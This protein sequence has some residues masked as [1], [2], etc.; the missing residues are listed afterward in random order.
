MPVRGWRRVVRWAGAAVGPEEPALV[1]ELLDQA[2]RLIV[3]SSL[4]A[5]PTVALMAGIL[6]GAAPRTGLV[7]WVVAVHAV[8]A[9]QLLLYGW[10]RRARRYGTVPHGLRAYVFVMAAAGAAWGSLA[11]LALPAEG[12]WQAMVGLFVIAFMASN[13]VFAAPL[14]PVFFAFQVPVSVVAVVGL[15]GGRSTFATLIAA[16]V[17][18]AL[19][20]SA[21]LHHQANTSAIAAVRL[22]HRN[23][24]L[25]N[26]LAHQAGH[27]ALTGLANRSLFREHLVAALAV[28]RRTGSTIGV[29]FVDLD[30]LKV[31]NDSL[32]HAV[33]DQ[34]LVA[35]AAR[36]TR[37]LRAGDVVARLGGDEFTV[38]LTPLHHS[39]EAVGIAE[40]IRSSLHE[41]FTVDGR[42]LRVTASIGLACSAGPDD[43]PDDLL[44]HADAALYRAKGL[45]RDRVE[46][47]DQSLRA[48][49]A[50]KVDE[51]SE[52]R[53]ALDRG[54]IVAWYQP[55]VDLDSGAIVAAEALAR[56]IHPAQGVL[57]AGTFVPLAEECGLLTEIGAVMARE[58]ARCRIEAG[59]FTDPR[60]R[61]HVNMAASEL[62]RPELLDRYVAFAARVG[63]DLTGIGIEV[64]ETAFI[65]DTERAGRWLATAR[66]YGITVSL[67]DFGTGYSS[68][69]L[70]TRLDLD[71]VKIDRSFVRDLTTNPAARAV[72]AATV[73]LARVLGL[74]VV[75]EGVETPA[76]AAALRALGVTRA[77]GFLFS[78]AVP[79]D[80][81]RTWLAGGPPWV[82][83]TTAVGS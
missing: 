4:A 21:L 80:T 55:V 40:R 12:E 75:A 32:G 37:C 59:R 72:V 65:S 24:A 83:A 52:L 33:G 2:S 64:T 49:L 16:V 18:Y 81:L 5:P 11:V 54:E 6:W 13:T 10:Y 60:F 31:I 76:Q 46:V 67:D 44:R 20:F 39:M 22:A 42:K 77:Q 62:V 9:A 35:A 15:L 27:D 58:T 19:P 66:R 53:H 48:A 34:V 50:R 78:P 29:L 26:R 7:G 82:V 61:V 45:G 74:E 51:E 41:P 73:E 79:G 8:T 28:A 70:L 38:L 14:R 17:A 1:D 43:T 23:E 30:R 47:F 69:A 25:V 71:G 36:F 56:W 57:G 68:L 63:L 3:R